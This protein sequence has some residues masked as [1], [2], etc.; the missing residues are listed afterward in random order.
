MPPTRP[1]L[2]W[3]RQHADD[4]GSADADDGEQ[5]AARIE[6]QNANDGLSAPHEAIVP[7]L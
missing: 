3:P 5:A 7:R 6:M 2:A 4:D 1:A